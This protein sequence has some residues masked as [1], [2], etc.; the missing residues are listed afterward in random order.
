M[1]TGGPPNGVLLSSDE[2]LLYVVGQGVWDLDPMG[3]PSNK[4][5]FPLNGADGLGLDCAGNVYLPNGT[6][7]NASGN[8]IG[9]FPGGTNL[10]FGGAD[11]KT[12]LVVGGGTTVRSIRMNVPGFP[13]RGTR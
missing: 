2:R 5:A 10:S 12:L 1:P 8:M 13:S 11:G 6:I 3:A 9:T 4:R 7:E